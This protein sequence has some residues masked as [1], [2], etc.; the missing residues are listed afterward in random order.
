MKR[1][2]AL[3]GFNNAH[4][5]LVHL[6]TRESGLVIAARKRT[7]PWGAWLNGGGTPPTPNSTT[8]TGKVDLCVPDNL[9]D[10]EP[11]TAVRAKKVGLI[12]YFNPSLSVNTS[13]SFC[14]PF[15]NTYRYYRGT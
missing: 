10:G 4:D 11:D 12:L 6:A 15:S 8:E 5:Y 9:S 13:P 2:A 7:A 3:A 1:I 14:P